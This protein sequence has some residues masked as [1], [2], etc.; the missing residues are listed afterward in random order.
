MQGMAME[1][2]KK[3]SAGMGVYLGLD[4]MGKMSPNL[5][6]TMLARREKTMWKGVR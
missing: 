2:N 6:Q 3:L 1:L 5:V 4:F